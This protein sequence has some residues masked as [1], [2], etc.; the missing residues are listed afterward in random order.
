[1]HIVCYLLQ[2]Q[3]W[4]LR[5]LIAQEIKKQRSRKFHVCEAISMEPQACAKLYCARCTAWCC[6]S[7]P[8]VNEWSRLLL[9]FHPLRCPFSS[10]NLRFKMGP[11]LA[12]PLPGVSRPIL[13]H[14]RMAGLTL[15]S[16]TNFGPESSTSEWARIEKSKRR[17]FFVP[18]PWLGQPAQGDK[19][20]T[21]M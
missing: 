17:L 5:N 14:A 9:P 21:I 15:C 12:P 1:V 2:C 20:F 3:S 6:P 19:S 11:I 8:D 18:L 16:Y 10:V 4:V 7:S 13:H